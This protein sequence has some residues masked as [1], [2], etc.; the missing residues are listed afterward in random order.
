MAGSVNAR[1]VASSP[2]ASSAAV[3]M[4]RARDSSPARTRAQAWA[5]RRSAPACSSGWA[6]PL[7]GLRGCCAARSRCS[8][9]PCSKARALA[10]SRARPCA[11]RSSVLASSMRG[12]SKKSFQA[13]QAGS[14][15]GSLDSRMRVRAATSAL[16]TAARMKGGTSC[17]VG[18]GRRN[19]ALRSTPS[20]VAQASSGSTATSTRCEH[21]S[22][23]WVVG[24][25]AGLWASPAR[26]R[27]RPRPR[28][29]RPR[30]RLGAGDG[31]P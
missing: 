3:N 24:T 14:P 28:P 7:R 27:P 13:R 1:Q 6:A 22:C 9:S 20:R 31:G 17:R 29:R 23:A 21:S 26:L 15:T 25:S 16:R 5:R 10:S 30:P 19:S 11:P 8:Q 12:A 18:T 2:G 4:C